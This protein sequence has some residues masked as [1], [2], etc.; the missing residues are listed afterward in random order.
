[1]P[2]A[3]HTEDPV[4]S[5][6]HG[7]SAEL[8]DLLDRLPTKEI[9]FKDKAA[10]SDIGMQKTSSVQPCNLNNPLSASRN[11]PALRIQSNKEV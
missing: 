10:L 11:K 1:M 8:C 2:K 9:V 7:Q 4:S 5:D 6:A 3:A